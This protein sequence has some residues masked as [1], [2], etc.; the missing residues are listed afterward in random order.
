MLNSTACSVSALVVKS[1]CVQWGTFWWPLQH[2]CAT[3]WGVMAM[4][5]WAQP[6][7]R[8]QQGA[9]LCSLAVF[10][11]QLMCI[12]GRGACFW[13]CMQ[14][15]ACAS[16]QPACRF[17]MMHCYFGSFVWS[18]IWSTRFTEMK[19][20]Q[21]LSVVLCPLEVFTFINWENHCY[22]KQQLLEVCLWPSMARSK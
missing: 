3:W 9:E 22:F 11:H 15:R 16:S 2:S 7:P 8:Q 21:P 13:I 10:A 19:G 14:S 17:S 12:Q 5:S 18:L 4:G 20:K 1:L 6:L